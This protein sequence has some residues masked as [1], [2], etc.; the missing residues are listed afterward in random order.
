M[1]Y[2]TYHGS[3]AKSATVHFTARVAVLLNRFFLTYMKQSAKTCGHKAIVSLDS[4]KYPSVTSVYMNSCMHSFTSL[5]RK[6]L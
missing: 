6:S 3:R 4:L 2:F 5:N 1:T